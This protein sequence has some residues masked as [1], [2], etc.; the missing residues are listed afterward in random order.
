MLRLVGQPSPRPRRQCRA[1]TSAW[2]CRWCHG[3]QTWREIKLTP[4]KF[5]AS[6]WA[7][8]APNDTAPAQHEA[9][10]IFHTCQGQGPKQRRSLNQKGKGLI[11]RHIAPAVPV[12]A[13]IRNPAPI[14]AP[15]PTDERVGRL[16][17]GL[18]DV[19]R[20]LNAAGIRLTAD[21][22]PQPPSSDSSSASDD[23]VVLE[24]D[25]F[26]RS[27]T[28]TPPHHHQ[29]SHGG[30]SSTR[31]PPGAFSFSGGRIRGVQ[32]AR[33]P[34]GFLVL[35]DTMHSTVCND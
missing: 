26:C 2:A 1:T 13:Y 34:S 31:P 16:E 20:A 23:V 4:S 17:Q 11:S 35:L 22:P 10:R 27:L 30:L 9:L 28:G 15:T 25:E 29:E 8:R 3:Q 6:F 32:G 24:S 14:R 5:L 19:R 18:Q 33:A 12:G 7:L 21:G